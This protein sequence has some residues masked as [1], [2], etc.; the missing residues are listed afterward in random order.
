MAYPVSEKMCST[1]PWR[2][3]S[4]GAFLRAELEEA[5]FKTSRICHSTG[6][7]LVKIEGAKRVSDEPLICRGSRNYQL[8]VLCGIGFLDAPTDEAWEKKAR[9][10]KG[11]NKQ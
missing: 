2:E 4:S 6:E 9:G 3:G 7:I 8:Q 11:S 1:C 10:L 5:S